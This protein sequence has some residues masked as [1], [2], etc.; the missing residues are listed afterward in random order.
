MAYGTSYGGTNFGTFGAGMATMGGGM[1]GMDPSGGGA[2]MGPYS[3]LPGGQRGGQG[4]YG[5]Y[6]GYGSSGIRP[7][8]GMGGG[9][10]INTTG[11]QGFLNGVVSGNNLPYSQQQQDSLYASASS[12]NAQAEQ[13]QNNQARQQAA[14]GGASGTDPS[15]NS[16]TQQNAA[17]R[18]GQ[19]QTAL[20]DIQS[21]AHSANFGSQSGAATGLLN[22][23]VQ[24]AGLNER[25]SEFGQG[26]QFQQNQSA[27]RMLGNMYGGGGN[28][29][30]S[31]G[32]NAGGAGTW[33][34]GGNG[35]DF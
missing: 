5:G 15:L 14:A 21:Q 10:N 11:A 17:R 29:F 2:S 35:F 18:Q 22:A 27:Q 26:L 9:T 33:M 6:G 24:M 20:G 25:A 19:N 8:P 32:L 13:E 28:Q 23:G 34:R 12:S 1:Y 16:V 7:M 3:F 4:G 31:V 30:G